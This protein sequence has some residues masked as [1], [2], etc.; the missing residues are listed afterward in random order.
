MI[1][2]RFTLFWS[3]CPLIK[4]RSLELV[5]DLKNFWF[6]KSFDSGF[7]IIQTKKTQI[8]NPFISIIAFRI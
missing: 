7:F 4:Y 3:K 6:P 5:P 8:R 2:I 1:L